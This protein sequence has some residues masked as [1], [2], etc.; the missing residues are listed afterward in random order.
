M[1]AAALWLTL[2]GRDLGAIWQALLAGDYRYLAAFL[3]ILS[4]YAWCVGAC[5]LSRS[6]PFPLPA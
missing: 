5:S 2:R 4:W 3:A 6:L 1:S